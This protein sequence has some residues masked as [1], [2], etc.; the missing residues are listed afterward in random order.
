MDNYIACSASE[1]DITYKFVNGP[2]DANWNGGWE[3]VPL[4]CAFGPGADRVILVP[5][6][7]SAD[8]VCF[9][10][11]SNR[12]ENYALDVTFNVDMNGVTGFTAGTDVP[13]VFGSYNDWT[14]QQ[15]LLSDADN[16]GVYTG[17][18]SGLGV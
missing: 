18:V 10:S 9:S 7:A 14:A 12:I 17:T 4:D 2:I 8:T 11:C 1:Q 16:D 6:A 15:D 5:P 13:Y 3:D